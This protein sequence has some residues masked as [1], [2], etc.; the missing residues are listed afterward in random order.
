MVNNERSRNVVRKIFV[1]PW[2]LLLVVA[3][4][5]LE[6]LLVDPRPFELYAMT[7]H[8]FFL[9]MLAFVFGF[10][11][12]MAGPEF[13]SGIQRIRWMLFVAAISLFLSRFLEMRQSA[14]NVLLSIEAV[15]WV[16]SAFA[17]GSK[18]LN[19][20]SNAL[21]YLSSA[22]YPVYILHMLVLDVGSML[23]FPLEI[24]GWIMYA[25]LLLFTLTGCFALYEVFR[26]VNWIRPLLGL[27][28]GP[29]FGRAGGQSPIMT[30]AP[31]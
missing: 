21:S 7:W 31:Q 3:A 29:C 23:L 17:F 22:A 10:L 14:P 20:P 5:V 9:G 4:F 13:W 26:R 1:S 24:N 25:V 6:A 12:V 27:K 8:G 19:K 28:M 30:K 2:G 18:Y 11:F 16:M 15:C